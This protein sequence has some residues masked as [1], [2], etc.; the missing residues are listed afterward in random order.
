M[1]SDLSIIIVNWNTRELLLSSIASVYAT[2]HKIDFEVFVED[3]CSIDGSP[4]MV[5]ENYPLVHL[6]E[7]EINLG[8]AKANNQA[9]QLCQGEY[10]LLLN[11]D[12]FLQENVVAQLMQ[13]A[14][15]N[16]NA[17][18]LGARLVYPDGRPQLS[19]G[20]L[21][22]LRSEL[23]SLLG[24]DKHWGK[25]EVN[26]YSQDVVQTGYVNGACLLIRRDLL[27]QIGL[28]DEQFFF[29]SEEIDLCYRAH[30]AGWH[31][32]HVPAAEVVHVGGGSTVS[33]ASRTLLLYRGKLLYFKKHH[34][35]NVQKR[36]LLAMRATSWAKSKAY[37]L[38]KKIIRGRPVKDHI[39][40]VVSAGLRNQ[41]I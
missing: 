10:I 12:A 24:L 31:V 38:R 25:N 32:L 26:R 5:R 15:D 37:A 2:I 17:G 23:A 28:F 21:P 8:F 3:N 40:Q 6:L 11:S 20:P 9:I 33:S 39:W 7:N 27:D 34:G 4:Q 19:H 29:F 1:P 13:A 16:P 35:S 36:L 22:T 30:Q 14:R 41:N 18:I